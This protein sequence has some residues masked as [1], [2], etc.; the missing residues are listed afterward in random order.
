MLLNKPAIDYSLQQKTI[1][2][3]LDCTSPVKII[4]KNR[5]KMGK[6]R[7]LSLSVSGNYSGIFYEKAIGIT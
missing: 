1:H 2:L 4:S 5:V 3:I 7:N 6:K